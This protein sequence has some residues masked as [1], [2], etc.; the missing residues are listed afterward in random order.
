MSRSWSIGEMERGG[1][2]RF[3]DADVSVVPPASGKA[4]ERV[5]SIFLQLTC[6]NKDLIDPR[7]HDSSQEFVELQGEV[8]EV[9]R[10]WKRKGAADDRAAMKTGILKHSGYTIRCGNFLRGTA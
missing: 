6:S 10:D 3:F 4:A 5:V 1:N 2:A 9:V 8:I 7:P